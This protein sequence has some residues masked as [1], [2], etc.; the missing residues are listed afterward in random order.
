MPYIFQT[1]AEFLWDVTDTMIT[2]LKVSSL[3][4]MQ[5]F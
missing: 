1:A 4:N 5:D 3:Q 2:A